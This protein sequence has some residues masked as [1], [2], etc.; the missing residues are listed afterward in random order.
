[1]EPLGAVHLGENGRGVEGGDQ[2]RARLAQVPGQR[3]PH[4]RAGRAAHPAR[5]LRRPGQI[6]L[7]CRG[8]NGRDGV[9]QRTHRSARR[10]GLRHPGE[11]LVQLSD[12]GPEGPVALAAHRRSIHLDD[13][14]AQM[15]GESGGGPQVAV[16]HVDGGDHG[17]DHGGRCRLRNAARCQGTRGWE[18]RCTPCE[19]PCSRPT[20]RC[21]TS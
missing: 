19:L 7:G 14:R 17:L 15:V 11:G 3:A 4:P 9:Q 16:S 12:A 10:G 13:F 2:R 8:R 20:F 18:R 1:M 5:A 21:C 6:A